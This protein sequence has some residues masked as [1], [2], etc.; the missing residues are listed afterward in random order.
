MYLYIIIITAGPHIDD[1]GDI[2]NILTGNKIFKTQ[3]KER[4][5]K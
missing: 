5:I 1:S 4:K 3:I 2:T